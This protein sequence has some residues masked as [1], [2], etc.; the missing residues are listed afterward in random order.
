MSYILTTLNYTYMLSFPKNINY[1]KG[2][3]QGDIYIYFLKL[4]LK[5][6]IML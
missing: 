2:H 1:N 5:Y 6:A 3:C 4:F